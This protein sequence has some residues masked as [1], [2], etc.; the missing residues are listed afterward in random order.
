MGFEFLSIL[1]AGNSSV[2]QPGFDSEALTVPLDFTAAAA[3]S[4]I[5]SAAPGDVM[6]ILATRNVTVNLHHAGVTPE[7]YATNANLSSFFNVLS[8]NLDRTGRAFVSTVEANNYPIRGTQ[9]HPER[10]Q[11][12]WNPALNLPHTGDAVTAMS[13]MAQFFVSEARRNSQSVYASSR[14][15]EL[16]A[17]LTTYNMTAIPMSDDPLEG[18]YALLYA[19]P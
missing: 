1:A 6:N 10:P 4:R 19:T 2:L 17:A 16:A 13:W 3:S 12:E 11:F 14:A 7:T 18:Y 8:T 5:F 15:T 9:W